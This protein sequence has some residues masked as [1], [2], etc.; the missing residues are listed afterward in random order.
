MPGIAPGDCKDYLRH[1]HQTHLRNRYLDFNLTSCQITHR[2]RIDLM[3]G[4]AGVVSNPGRDITSGFDSRE[5]GVTGV[6]R[7]AMYFRDRCDGRARDNSGSH[8]L[9]RYFTG[10]QMRVC[11]AAGGV[12]RGSLRYCS[13]M[14]KSAGS[15]PLLGSHSEKSQLYGLLISLYGPV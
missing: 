9:T 2:P 4:L 14:G 8:R 7:V 13:N 15:R 10:R 6:L 1:G 11:N 5:V 3:R 12:V